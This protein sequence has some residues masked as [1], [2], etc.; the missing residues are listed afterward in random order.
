MGALGLLV[1]TLISLQTLQTIFWGVVNHLGDIHEFSDFIISTGLVD[2]GFVGSR[3]TW[4]N[5]KIWKQLDRVFSNIHGKIKALDLAAA[6]AKEAFDSNN[7]EENRIALS[8]AQSNLSLCLSMEEA[9]WKQKASAKW[10]VEGEKN[11]KLFHN[12]VNHRRARNTNYRIWDDGN[13]LEN[14]T[15]IMESGARFF[16]QLLTGPDGFSEGFYQRCWDIVKDD[17][18][19]AIQDFWAGTPLRRSV[20]ATTIILI[21]KNEHAQRWSDFRPIS[22]CNVNN[23]IITKILTIR[24]SRIL[25]R[26]ISSSQS[27]FVAGKMISDNILLA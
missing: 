2:A 14:P 22:L 18:I 6:Q 17:L 9:F 10:L 4:M 20:I 24:L 12:M 26:I 1:L 5:T 23:K 8:L 7:S 3:F 19:E 11:S 21:P 25:P 27:G 16:D 13:S 15:L